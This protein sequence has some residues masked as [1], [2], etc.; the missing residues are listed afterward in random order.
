MPKLNLP[1]YES[2]LA[3][4][5]DLL[6]SG[7]YL[8][9][10]LKDKEVDVTDDKGEIV[11][12][13]YKNPYKKLISPLFADEIINDY[14]NQELL[15]ILTGEIPYYHLESTIPRTSEDGEFLSLTRDSGLNDVPAP[16]QNQFWSVWFRDSQGFIQNDLLLEVYNKLRFPFINEN[17]YMN[18][19]LFPELS[20]KAFNSESGNNSL[21]EFKYTTEDNQADIDNGDQGCVD[22]LNNI[23]NQKL[24]SNYEIIDYNPD[25]AILLSDWGESLYQSGV[26]DISEV[27]REKTIFKLQDLRY[28]LVRRKFAGSATL[29]ALAVSS[30]DRQGS[31]IGVIPAGRLQSEFTVFKDQRFIR[32]VDIPGLLSQYADLTENKPILAFYKRPYT[33]GEN[34]IPLGT[35]IPLFYSSSDQGGSG[36]YW[37][38]PES[39][40]LYSGDRNGDGKPDVM[41]NFNY[42]DEYI[43]GLE[44]QNMFLRDNSRVLEWE[45]L[46]GITS[47]DSINTFF[48][49]LDEKPDGVHYRTMDSDFVAADGTTS[50]MR[51]DIE[52]PYFSLSSIVGNFLDISANHLLYHE[53]VIQADLGDLYPYL[54]YPIASG[55][56]V[57]LMDVPW[58]EY[59]ENCTER[60]SR[61]QD[62]VF[63]GTQINKYISF[64]NSQFA[65]YAFFGIT[66]DTEDKDSFDYIEFSDFY[67]YQDIFNKTGRKPK[68][69]YLWYITFSYDILDFYVLKRTATLISKITLKMTEEN[70]PNL[71]YYKEEFGDIDVFNDLQKVNLGILPL[72]Y[73]EVKND[74]AALTKLG[75]R[76]VIEYN[77]DGSIGREYDEFLDTLADLGYAKA[78]YAFSD[79]DLVF[80]RINFQGS[81]PEIGL[82]PFSIE[83]QSKA[84]NLPTYNKI[85]V[86][87]GV[88][89]KSVFFCISREIENE[90]RYYWSEP[91][92]VLSVDANFM[93]NIYNQSL[94]PDWYRLEFH[95]NPYL[96]FTKNSAST[97]RRKEVIPSFASDKLDIEESLK[98]ELLIGPGEYAGL[99]T[100]S[101]TRGYKFTCNNLGTLED[102]DPDK[103][104]GFYFKR[105]SPSK[106]DEDFHYRNRE[107]VQVY[108]D[109]RKE[110]AYDLN[111]LDATILNRSDIYE[112]GR[113]VECIS[114]QEGDY[115]NIAIGSPLISTNYFL[116][117]P[118]D[119]ELYTITDDK[120][121][122]TGY[123]LTD[124]YNNW[125]WNYPSTG[126]TAFMDVLFTDVNKI[127]KAQVNVD[128]SQEEPIFNI[129]YSTTRIIDNVLLIQRKGEDNGEINSEFSLRLIYEKVDD[130]IQTKFR[131]EYYPLG[132]CSADS[133]LYIESDPYISENLDNN[134]TLFGS[135]DDRIDNGEYDVIFNDYIPEL[136]DYNT[137]I[138]V[139]AYVTS[140]L[141][142]NTVHLSMVINNKLYTKS[143]VITVA[144]DNIYN[145]VSED[146]TVVL[147]N[148][149]GFDYR[150]ESTYLNKD[151]NFIPGYPAKYY[152]GTSI[153]IFDLLSDHKE[154]DGEVKQW[155]MFHGNLY[156]IRLYNIGM[157]PYTLQIHNMGLVREQ[158]SYAPSS[159][160]L[161]YSVYNDFGVFKPVK[162]IPITAG[163]ISEVN[164]IRLFDRTVWDS[165]LTDMYCISMDEMDA[166]YPQYDEDFRD[167]KDDWDVYNEEGDL[168]CIE[169]NLID[170]SEVANNRHPN[171]TADNGNLIVQYNGEKYTIDY[172]D[173]ATII[174]TS[175]YPVDYRNQLF[176]SNSNLAAEIQGNEILLYNKQPNE[177]EEDDNEIDGPITGNEEVE[178][179]PTVQN[180]G[181]T[182]PVYQS[183]N[184]LKYN[185]EL[186]LNFQLENKSDLSVFYSRGN[187]IEL[188]Y[189]EALQ[190]STVR[191]KNTTTRSSTDNHIL[192]PMTIPLNEELGGLDSAYIDRL[193]LS[194]L[195]LNN[196]ILT[197]LKASSYYS[198][199]RLPIAIQETLNSVPRYISRW[200]AIRGL[201]EGTYYFTVKYPFEI[202]PFMD[203]EYNSLT[204]GKFAPLYGAARFKIEVKGTPIRYDS[205]NYQIEGYPAQYLYSNI[206]N[207]LR[208]GGS[209]HDPEDNRTYPHRRIDIDLYVMDSNNVVGVMDNEDQEQY[210]FEWKKI[211]SNYE[212]TIVDDYSEVISVKVPQ[213]DE[214]GKPI[215]DDDGNPTYTTELQPV[216]R[217]L[218]LLDKATLDNPLVI[219]EKIPLFLTKNY[220]SPFF[221]AKFEKGSNTYN[222]LSADD[223]TIIPITVFP[224]YNE[225]SLE[226]EK[227]TITTENDLDDLRLVS[228]KSYKILF[229]YD[230]KLTE[231]SFVDKIFNSQV[232]GDD[233]KLTYTRM[234]NLLE[235][236]SQISDYIY[237]GSVGWYGNNSVSI[238]SRISGFDTIDG[239]WIEKR[240]DVAEDVNY[241]GNPYSRATSYNYILEI[242]P[243]NRQEVDNLAY[244]PYVCTEFNEYIVPAR[245]YTQIPAVDNRNSGSNYII[246][247]MSFNEN[248]I[249]ASLWNSLRGR[250]TTAI[251]QLT[252]DVS[253]LF[254]NLSYVSPGLVYRLAS[255]LD[256]PSD[257]ILI[258]APDYDLYAY[259]ASDRTVSS[260]NDNI[261]IT[262]RGVYSNNLIKN[263]NFLNASYWALSRGGGYVSDLSWDNGVGKDVFRFNKMNTTPS[264]T[265]RYIS[266]SRAIRANY[267]TAINVMIRSASSPYTDYKDNLS[268]TAHF[269]RSNTKIGSVDLTDIREAQ[270]SG[271]IS[272]LEV[273][274][275]PEAVKWYNYSFEMTTPLE[276]D[277][278]AFEF[279]YNSTEE[280][281]LFVTKPV[282]RRSSSTSHRL[283][284]SDA[285]YT[286]STSDEYSKVSCVSHRIVFFRNKETLQPVPIQFKNTVKTYAASNTNLSMN[287][288]VESG[289][290]R[291]ID[292]IKSCSLG[293]SSESSKLEVLFKPWDRRMF[294]WD[295]KEISADTFKRNFVQFYGYRVATDSLGVKKKVISK[296][297]TT[298]I[299]YTKDSYLLDDEGNIVY[300]DEGNPIIVPALDYEADTNQILIH[301]LI[302]KTRDGL[303]AGY[304][305]NLR[306]YLE[307]PVELLDERFSCIA[308]CFDVEKFKK[309]LS[310]PVAITNIQ[311]VGPLEASSGT[312]EV[313]YEF[314][315]LPVI[316]D[317][318]DQHISVNILLHKSI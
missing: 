282:I 130:T 61:V 127:G 255:N 37:Y 71:S 66:Y 102:H 247:N 21:V 132:T 300:D 298:D 106:E 2:T 261:T 100:M 229:D 231:L 20:L 223:D 138:G 285:L 158:Y 80:D 251:G 239:G 211:A 232:I 301:G 33:E 167:P 23:V 249:L 103:P 31:F 104:F 310:N 88:E 295:K 143:Y 299:Y 254:T 240:T 194:S 271:E 263:K 280:A 36:Q 200:D 198:E 201:K 306:I 101:N 1:K 180:I 304:N 258:M 172:N 83:S 169:Q 243:E 208:S 297:P 305:T 110:D 224:L 4:I 237:D 30:I 270:N 77:E 275:D 311:L 156:D 219:K 13:R 266:G 25:Q 214:E 197:F 265:M 228:G 190:Q 163:N 32:V 99:S 245:Y 235:E 157:N 9:Y 125:Y 98:E 182:L 314:E 250:I 124:V 187:N 74:N 210:N 165:I 222:P 149:V 117:E 288:Y 120:I 217:T 178:E 316:Y 274:P 14:N 207:T 292:F 173:W 50:P 151:E 16:M 278:V 64:T 129:D 45:Q 199:F 221:I 7:S 19:S 38:D 230:A 114:F 174:T 233:E 82:S 122:D 121:G 15:D 289:Q 273:L 26:L 236:D 92:R 147:N 96:N 79:S 139:S 141:D 202:L 317:E 293:K 291:V 108:G 133:I 318:L 62:R 307:D 184:T 262:R 56:S 253:G 137:R 193:N 267:E 109:N 209:I 168:V 68:Y 234:V 179:E 188:I 257:D 206:N 205:G 279:K 244:F 302:L 283:G 78:Y 284:L 215:L 213:V 176:A 86:D 159:Y 142:D 81:D 118:F 204:N 144:G 308:N 115:K 260:R 312:R 161:A 286:V 76:H 126:I 70:Y 40:L 268:I 5:K 90:T 166:A 97:L 6:V 63:F 112:D 135:N 93:K 248:S 148:A 67:S 296:I 185:T 53:N 91:I 164:S 73:K 242:T 39:F 216:P 220:T 12:D 57:S 303:L 134:W 105:V 281:D 119:H 136:Q 49:R 94:P 150:P 65:E 27:E 44:Y 287:H 196:G 59:L 256:P 162:G 145:A 69:A 87:P 34:Y 116:I 85:K 18:A 264:V 313:L 192:I 171:T 47:E 140:T 175:L 35:V 51:L 177:Y 10:E 246:R 48:P 95:I 252:S 84:E 181:I 42:G 43:T 8:M 89:T 315:Y 28:E 241:F 225:L 154:E 11:R 269:Y 155:N 238:T 153:G 212:S 113:G 46:S 55:N 131:F 58:I 111:A 191:L 276:A 203:Y 170:T 227:L 17:Q 146:E 152:P 189:N 107:Y 183:G 54:T 75:F 294:Y 41:P 186:S 226:L 3:E 218:V 128:T 277:S 259:Y 160:K 123:T 22:Y 272:T 290:S 24:L 72:T 52:I 60:K 29:Y 195:Q 309:K